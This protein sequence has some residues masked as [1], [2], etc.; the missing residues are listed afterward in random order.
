MK[1]EELRMKNEECCRAGALR[2]PY[3]RHCFALLKASKKMFFLC[4]VFVVSCDKVK[5]G[6]MVV[7]I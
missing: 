2:Q 6:R 5:K 4:N 3:S 7:G 1:N